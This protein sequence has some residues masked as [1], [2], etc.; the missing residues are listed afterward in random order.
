[1]SC[2]RRKDKRILWSFRTIILN[3][4]TVASSGG[5]IGEGTVGAIAPPRVRVVSEEFFFGNQFSKFVVISEIL[6]Q[7]QI[8]HP[9]TVNVSAQFALTN[10]PTMTLILYLYSV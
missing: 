5:S 8:Y 6:P 1:M 4:T 3:V 9:R 7:L 10:Q 2:S